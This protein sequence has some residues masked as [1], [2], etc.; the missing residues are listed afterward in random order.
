MKTKSFWISIGRRLQSPSGGS[1]A[2]STYV[3]NNEGGCKYIIKGAENNRTPIAVS[4]TV[5]DVCVQCS[6]SWLPEDCES[7]SMLEW[8]VVLSPLL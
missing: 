8:A 3:Y 5:E 7:K 2:L 4:S 1:Y 6:S